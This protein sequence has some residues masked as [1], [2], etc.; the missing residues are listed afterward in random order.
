MKGS[1]K[2]EHPK[3]YQFAHGRGATVLRAIS[4][5]AF[6]LAISS[7]VLIVFLHL[8]KMFCAGFSPWPL[9][10]AIP[11][12]LIGIAFASLQFALQRTLEQIV[13]GLLVS[14]A[15][16]LWGIE[17]FLT[18]QETISFIDDIVVFLFVLDLAIAIYEH[19]KP[20]AHGVSNEMPFEP[21]EDESPS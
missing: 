20:G 19:L 21:P 2:E 6:G 18:N 12:M 13:M 4:G 11:L 15:F 10:S 3:H 7:A 8:I 1:R 9:K 17:Q 14:L 5:I 16:I